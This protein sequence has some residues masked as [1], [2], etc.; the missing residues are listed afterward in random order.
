L[1]ECDVSIYRI[2]LDVKSSMLTTVMELVDGDPDITLVHVTNAADPAL[3]PAPLPPQTNG[4][5]YVGGKRNKTVR[6]DALVEEV[7]RSG[8]ATMEEIRQAFVHHEFAAASAGAY[9]SKMLRDGRIT[10][11]PHGRYAWVKHEA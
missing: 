4:S 10:N 3:P 9:V 5:R 2:T 11:K 1:K 7:L 8:P 6:G